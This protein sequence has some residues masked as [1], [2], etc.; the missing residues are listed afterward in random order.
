[1]TSKKFQERA[2]QVHYLDDRGMP[3]VKT[4]IDPGY[5]Y[6]LKERKHWQLIAVRDK[7]K[8]II[9]FEWFKHNYTDYIKK[10]K[11]LSIRNRR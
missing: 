3:A 10:P 8:R 6:Q 4:E 11:P 2:V 7:A 1:M 9:R 5:Y